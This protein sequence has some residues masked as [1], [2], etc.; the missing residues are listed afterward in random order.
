MSGVKRYKVGLN[1]IGCA[2][3]YENDEGRFVRYDDYERDIKALDAKLEDWEA[4]AN[5][6]EQER[7][8][9]RT[10]NQ[11][12]EGEVARL[13]ELA[14]QANTNC[15]NLITYL[16]KYRPQLASEFSAYHANIESALAGTGEEQ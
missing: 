5:L 12:L 1:S 15:L 4:D 9:L 14:E 2:V 7:D 8:T 16:T 6:L 10:A 11:R 13:R 3:Y